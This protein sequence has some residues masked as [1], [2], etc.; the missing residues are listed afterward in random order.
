MCDRFIIVLVYWLALESFGRIWRFIVC[1][2]V[3]VFW[4]FIKIIE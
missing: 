4:E 3:V 1:L 2:L